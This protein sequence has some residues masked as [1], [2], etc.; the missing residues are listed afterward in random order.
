MFLKNKL[1]RQ[2]GWSRALGFLLVIWFIFI[3]VAFGLL[4][5]ETD[6]QFNQRLNEAFKDVKLLQQ[7]RDEVERLFEKYISG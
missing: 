1:L 7:Q 6:P 5:H 4:K 3:I 2:L